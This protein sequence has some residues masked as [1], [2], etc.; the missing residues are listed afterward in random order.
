MIMTA[1]SSI[2]VNPD[3]S[4]MTWLFVSGFVVIPN[5]FRD[6]GIEFAWSSAAKPWI[7]LNVGTIHAWHDQMVKG[8]NNRRHSVI[9][10][11]TRNPVSLWI[12]AFAGM[13]ISV[14]LNA[15]VY[16]FL[17]IFPLELT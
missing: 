13:T 2:N 9:P 3:G 14:V 5:L 16:I 8:N 6:L 15:A 12:P 4:N 10:G 1:T 7:N 17:I 11:L